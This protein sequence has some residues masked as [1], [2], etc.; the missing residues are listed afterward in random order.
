L[1]MPDYDVARPGMQITVRLAFTRDGAILGEPRFTF[2][3]PGVSPIGANLPNWVL[4]GPFSRWF[5]GVA[6]NVFGCGAQSLGVRLGDHR[7]DD[8]RDDQAQEAPH[9]VF[10]AAARRGE[11][12]RWSAMS[13]SV[14][15][16]SKRLQRMCAFALLASSAGG[17]AR[18]IP[19]LRCLKAISMR[20]RNR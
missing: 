1:R 12:P 11:S 19:L 7:V 8:C 9:A 20:Q 14:N 10:Y 6:S 2:T 3:T 18:P 4:I 13:G 15:S 16:A 5:A 17:P